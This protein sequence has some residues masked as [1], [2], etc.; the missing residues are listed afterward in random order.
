MV[1]DAGLDCPTWF[2][3]RK[4]PRRCNPRFTSGNFALLVVLAKSLLTQLLSSN[5]VLVL[6][7]DL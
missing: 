5:C 3:L 6:L 2:L 1:G 7:G 4:N